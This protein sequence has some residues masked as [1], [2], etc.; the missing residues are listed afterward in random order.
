MQLEARWQQR[1]QDIC[2]IADAN[3]S[4]N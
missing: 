3:D 1:Q 2:I 4:N